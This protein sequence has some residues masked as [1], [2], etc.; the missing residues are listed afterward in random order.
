MERVIER[1]RCPQRGGRR[2]AIC[3]LV[4]TALVAIAIPAGAEALDGSKRSSAQVARNLRSSKDTH[5]T[6]SLWKQSAQSAARTRAGSGDP[7]VK[8]DE[9]KPFTLD[10]AG[11]QAAL[12]QAPREGTPAAAQ[13]PLVLSLPAPDDGFQRFA[14]VESP[15]M[16]PALARDH[17]EITTYSGR[18]IDDLAATIRLDLSP[19]GFHA[20]VRSPDGNWYIDP[21]FHDDQTQYASYFASDLTESPHGTFVFRDPDEEEEA[22]AAV[23]DL[24]PHGGGPKAGTVLRTYRLGLMSDPSYATYFGAGKVTAAKV[25]LMNRVDQIYED[26]TSIRMVLIANNDLLNLDTAALATDPNG[27]C[28]SAACFTTAQLA[29]GCTGG[30]LTRNRLV[31]G[32]IIGA[33][34]YDIGHIVLGING[35]GVASLGVVGGNSKAQGCTG[36]PQPDGD[37]FAVD[38]V[39]HEMGHQFAGNHSFNGNQLNCSGGNRN[40]ATSVEPGSGSSIMAYAGI[41]RQDDLQPHSDPY[42][43]ERSFEEITNYVSSTRPAINEV[44]NVAL[45]DFDGTDSF[46]VDYNGTDSTPIVNG[47]S[48]TQAGVQAA[49]QGPSEIQTVSLTGYDTDGDSYSLNYNG[50]G[51]TPIV[52]G[53]N[54]TAAGIANALQGGNEQ[55][56][57][58]LAGF[59]GAAQSFQVQ[60]GGNSSAV[61]GAGG[62]AINNGNVAAAIN[63]IPG[64][65][66]TVTSAGAGN[67]GFTLTF[68]GA[69]ANTDVPAIAIVN[70]TGTCTSTVRETAKGG[71]AIASWPAGGTVAVGTL[72]DGGYTLTFSGAFQGTDVSLLA[73]TNGVGVSGSVA[74]TT[75]GAP[76]ILPIGAT[77]TVAPYFNVAPFNTAGFQVTF[78]G[79]LGLVNVSPL[80]LTN[81][82]GATSF[83]GETAKGG[84]ID[85]NGFTVTPTGNAPP[86]VS[87]P[88]AFTIPYR[89]P[90]ALTGGATDANGD[91]LTYLWEQNDPGTSAVALVNPS[92]TTGP[93]FRQ[94]GTALDAAIYDPHQFNSPGENHV[95]R[96]PERVFPDL[97]QILAN[98]T[99]A[100]TG[101]CPGAPA[102]PS[103]PTG[104][105]NVPQPLIDCYSEFLPT[106][107]YPGPI[108]FRLTARDGHPHGGGVAS[109]DTVLNL[110]PG[111]GPFLVTSQ[112][113]PAT[114]DSLTTQTVTWDVAGTNAA[115]IGTANVKISL[116]IDGGFTYPKVLAASTPNDGSETLTLPN[117]VAKQARIKVEAVGNVFFD[118]SDVDSLIRGV[119]GS[120]QLGSHAD[121][122]DAGRA[123]A[124]RYEAPG[125]GTLTALTFYL[126]KASKAKQVVVGV[127]SDKNDHPGTLLGK[128]RTTSPV[129]GDWNT[130]TLGQPVSVDGGASYWIAILSPQAE[131]KITYRDECCPGHGP[132]PAETSPDHLRDLPATWQTGARYPHDGPLSAYGFVAP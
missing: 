21:R 31:V 100:A 55:Q 69:S 35:G 26:E 15:I 67:T 123:K 82:S 81:L 102:P 112:G 28:G 96:N 60:I 89:T 58:V 71:V 95:T 132:S 85:N 39:A 79:V 45:R 115:P 76:G 1:R 122:T 73:V 120:Q 29:G 59:N 24:A 52:R 50:S 119:L 25:A 10:R 114:L 37:F 14:I 108:H 43:S 54:N 107:V 97:A 83:T 30:L 6:A 121:E 57:V 131:R 17:P 23:A 11:L 75:K 16:E 32:Q 49:I 109:S 128:A 22:L 78:G 64:F 18:G 53:Q 38:Y 74:E 111:T 34:S 90:F 103:P 7:I 36:L 80:T 51:T 47:T 4:L 12:E 125:T 92:K 104:G 126:D 3:G 113:A 68:G 5:A 61:L 116:S 93:L 117:V 62:L 2:L 127:Y 27:P 86:E 9:F 84:P 46:T 72:T 63:A 106:A 110:A 56:Q 65:A 40:G 19:L 124:F 98:N 130:L 44:Q 94:F 88:E 91:V 48:Y 33:S 41:C 13:Q 129:N 77:A 101:D 20:S 66:G 8:P 105:T 42:W 87:T 99:N 70:C 118:L